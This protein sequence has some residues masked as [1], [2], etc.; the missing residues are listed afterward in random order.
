M[1]QIDYAFFNRLKL[2]V[3]FCMILFFLSCEND[4][5]PVS[6]EFEIEPPTFEEVEKKSLIVHIEVAQEIPIDS[7]IPCKIIF[8]ENEDSLNVIGKIKRRGGYSIMYN[9]H[10]YKIDLKGDFSI[11]GLAADDDWILNANYIDKSFL[12]HTLSY[13]LFKKMN[14]ANNIACHWSYSEVYLNQQYNGLYVLME[15]LDRSTLMIEK[16]DT[17]TFIFKD[18]PIFRENQDEFVPQDLG[19]FHQ[20]N[21]PDIEEF[22][23]TGYI[24]TVRHFIINAGNTLFSQKIDTIF[25][26]ENIIDWHLLLMYTNNGDGIL[27]NFYLY[28]KSKNDLIQI[29]PWDYDHTFGRSGDNGLNLEKPIRP[30]RAVLLNRLLQ[31]DWYTTKLKKRWTQLNN[32]QI[33]GVEPVSKLIDNYVEELNPLV[34]KNFDLWP[35]HVWPYKDANTFKEEIDLIKRYLEIRQNQLDQYFNEL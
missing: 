7:E 18:P 14:P 15:R 35:V 30:E 1:N 26:I 17:T 25:D 34:E 31:L 32:E 6:Q 9:K 28:K 21:Y 13:E 2:A 11:D 33:F 29:A 16:P 24:N 12:R 27:K 19:N 20:Q 22:D 4:K 3:N 10:S 23:K 5:I 8:V